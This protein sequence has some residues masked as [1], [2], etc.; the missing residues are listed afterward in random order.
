[1]TVTVAKQSGD[2]GSQT[3]NTPIGR[4]VVGQLLLLTTP[5][6]SPFSV[7]GVHPQNHLAPRICSNVCFW[8]AQPGTCAASSLFLRQVAP[9][10][11]LMVGSRFREGSLC[12]KGEKK[13]GWSGWQDCVLMTSMI[14]S[15]L[16]GLPTSQEKL[17]T[18]TLNVQSL[19]P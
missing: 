19:N 4:G 8:R 14:G 10:F 11:H 2:V 7:T 9:G 6:C 17:E 13:A 12:C 18:W 5:A 1:M 3:G 16:S 15:A